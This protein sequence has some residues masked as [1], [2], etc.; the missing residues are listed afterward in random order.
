MITNDDFLEELDLSI[1]R[2]ISGSV[3]PT[4]LIYLV[5]S[6]LLLT[7]ARFHDLSG[8]QF[9]GAIKMPIIICL[10]T[11]FYSLTVISKKWTFDL[12]WMLLFLIVEA[13]RAFVGFFVFPNL[14]VNDAAQAYTW[15]DLLL[16]FISIMIPISL[17]FAYGR[18]LRALVNLLFFCGFVLSIWG[19]THSGHGP[20]GH[21]GDENDLC[22]VLVFLLPFAFLFSALSPNKFKK[23]IGLFFSVIC[24]LGI[25]STQSRGGFLGLVAAIFFQ[26]TLSKNKLKWLLGA[27]LIAIASL[28]FVPEQ[29][30]KEIKSIR[31]DSTAKTGTIDE[32][33]RTWQNI[34]RMWKDPRNTLTGVGLGNSRWMMKYYEEVG[35]GVINK[36]LAGRASHSFYFQVLGDLGLWGILFFSMNTYH[37]L[38]GLF[39]VKRE[40]IKVQNEFSLCSAKLKNI[41]DK[42][43][44]NEH[45]HFLN[46]IKKMDNELKFITLLSS[47]M[48]SG[49]FGF[50]ASATGISV[51]YYPTFW[52]MLSFS[53]AIYSYWSKLEISSKSIISKCQT[54]MA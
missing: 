10:I 32:R 53:T 23:L 50:L 7:F 35:S 49:W 36:S 16:Y 15:R 4:L 21:L 46:I 9:L 43:D 29:Y 37:S 28:P 24:I 40:V 14:V 6:N 22:L 52:L 2:D 34:F 51:S 41:F 17:T 1:N 27:A 25:V 54:L 26:F 33:F 39:K 30:Y 38:T 11:A 3:V 47:A 8:L 44:Q 20:G 19:I 48:L 45:T 18:T 13:L 5:I 12:N 42:N 31:T